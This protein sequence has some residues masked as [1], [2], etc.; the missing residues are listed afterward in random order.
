MT[1]SAASFS[2]SANSTDKVFADLVEELTVRLQ[3]GE[4]LDIESLRRDYPEYADRLEQLLPALRLL[5]NVSR[6]RPDGLMPVAP[7]CDLEAPSG[8]LGDF[9]ILRE[10]GRGGMGI[11]YEAEQISLGRRVAL[12]VLPF[13]ATMDPRHLH[14]FQNESRAAA[15]LEHP[16]IVPVYSVGCERGV[17]YYAMKF[18]EGHSLAAL[19]GQQRHTRQGAVTSEFLPLGSVLSPTLPAGCGL[20][21]TVPA[22]AFSTQRAPRDAAVFRRIARWGIEAA[23]ALEHAHSLGIVHRDIKPANLMIDSRGR[24]WI[25]DFGLARTAADGGLTMTGDVLGTLRYMSPE[26]AMAKHGLVDHRTD[27]YSL[28]VTLY[29]VLTGMQA[30]GGNDREQ[31]LNAITLDEPRPPRALDAAIPHDL[32]TIVLKALEKSAADRYDS[33]QAL[34]EDLRCFLDD[35]PIRAKRPRLLQR[36][37]RWSRRHGPAVLAG[38]AVLL[39]ALVFTALGGFILWQKEKEKNNA[40]GFAQQARREAQESNANLRNRI[41][42]IDI[43]LAFQDWQNGRPELSLE[44][45][46][47]YGPAG[48]QE[49]L[50]GFEWY[51]LNQLC[52]C[53]LRTLPAHNGKA[54]GVAFSHDG[55]LLAT[56]GKDGYVRIWAADTGHLK[57]E[58]PT[59]DQ[60]VNGVAFSPDNKLLASAGDDG[61]TKIWEVATG[62]LREIISKPGERVVGVGFLPDGAMLAASVQ[63]SLVKIWDVKLPEATV[64]L[65][66]PRGGLW[67]MAASWD[68][69]MIATGGDDGMIR[70]WDR[71]T[72]QLKSTPMAG[73]SKRIRDL[74]FSHDNLKLAS[75]CEDGKVKIWDIANA[76]EL[77]SIKA[78]RDAARTVAFSPD[79]KWL[80]SGG[81]ENIIYISNTKDGNLNNVIRGHTGSIYAVQFAPDS[82]T[83]AS[84]SDDGQVKLW[85]R[86]MVQQWQG[87]AD[88]PSY[89]RRIAFSPN[90]RRLATGKEDGT[91]DLWDAATG[92]KQAKF[93]TF[94]RPVFDL[95]WA[96][97]TLAACRSDPGRIIQF[98][99]PSTRKKGL[100]LPIGDVIPDAMALSPDGRILALGMDDGRVSL[101]DSST[102]QVVAE[103]S[104]NHPCSLAFA[105]DGQTLAIGARGGRVW[106]WDLKTRLVV[107]DL[108]GL[109]EDARW[110]GFSPNG[111]FLAAAGYRGNLA[112]WDLTTKGKLYFACNNRGFDHIAFSPDSN[113][114]AT[115]S[116][117]EVLLWNVATGQVMMRLDHF[118]D[119]EI[120]SVA[121]SPDGQTLVGAG[122]RSNCGYADLVFWHAPRDLARAK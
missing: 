106:L 80:A 26:Q 32:E 107:D 50:R 78:H 121:F 19:I 17:H 70:L 92:Q 110:T 9:R 35:K 71:S 43:G 18:I 37:K 46:D 23:E 45:L 89:F 51:Y 100:T 105:P 72:G 114:L 49:D 101:R 68:H 103:L 22:A 75:A 88:Y 83:L 13:A 41:Y 64:I 3:S 16:H 27:V 96:G 60:E 109:R 102:G 62:E 97:D 118:P 82:R 77:A 108:N 30:V 74:A 42:A 98:W 53:D 7:G 63:G 1:S 33:A 85:D 21:S 119:I 95:I 36:A 12:K 91:I 67:S 93:A 10:V 24:L 120:H 65:E 39:V 4:C 20:D 99:D 115:A 84:A 34:A 55:R 56:C 8:T 116:F 31:I 25:T 59:N 48:D 122:G 29:E 38:A 90:G 44:R 40:L 104:G 81:Y 52:H 54:Y 111:R 86:D 113:T 28:G 87:F 117:D 112:I 76:K 11:V 73:G 61:T 69:K 2:Q 5:A 15:S 47:Q 94:D 66:V 79:G 58:I 6:S 57:S 14:R